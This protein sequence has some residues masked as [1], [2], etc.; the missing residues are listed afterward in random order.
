[1][2]S[3]EA[4]LAEIAAL[5]GPVTTEP[6]ALADAAG[7]VLA[8]PV[9]AKRDQPPFA[10]SAMDGYA[11]RAAD[12]TVAARLRVIG[13]AVAGCR[14]DGPV[15]PGETVRIFT[16]APLPDGADT[17]LIQEDAERASDGTI[18]VTDVPTQHYVRPAGGD[19]QRGAM[20]EAPRRLAPA[21]LALA[22]AMN[23]PDLT[24]ARRPQVALI[25]TGNELVPPGE[26]PDRDQIIG[27]NIFALKALV[28]AEGANARL[29]PIARDSA[30]SLS[31]T[32]GLARSADLIL[33]TGG[34]SV[35]DHDLVSPVAQ[36][37]G[38][39]LSFHKV[40]MRPGK[41]LMAGRLGH[42][43]LV[44]LPG[45]P[46]SS[47]V[48]GMIFVRP[49]LRAMQG[50]PA[51]P[52]PRSPAILA[53]DLSANG[54]REHYMRARLEDGRIRAFDRQDSSLLS[55]LAQANALLVRPPHDPAR[56]A[57]DTVEMIPLG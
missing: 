41:P 6:V 10:A 21:D 15:G 16:G 36:S 49:L 19:F 47:I 53:E 17:I 38:M 51:E 42:S 39:D 30:E 52:L 35:G 11:V 24:V 43:I 37:M 8:E 46:V 20:L 45:N 23:V 54:P 14:Y 48:C 18:R 22:A 31:T 28:E 25:A 34:A 29:L 50:L 3:V 55:V 5:V 13:E 40:A 2:I 12:M 32:L 56:C 9:T 44:G 7:R 57:G 26:M 33:T 1:M 4:A 27:S